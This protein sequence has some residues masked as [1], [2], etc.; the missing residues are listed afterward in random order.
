[1]SDD[2]RVEDGGVG[3][4][5]A[6]SVSAVSV[7]PRSAF[8]HFSAEHRA[9]IKA[10]FPDL[11]YGPTG[12]TSSSSAVAPLSSSTPALVSS[13]AF[14]FSESARL[15]GWQW[16]RMDEA[17]RRVYELRAAADKE[18]YRREVQL[19]N[20]NK[21]K[22]QT[23]ETPHAPH[24]PVTNT[25]HKRRAQQNIDGTTK[26]SKQQTNPSSRKKARPAPSASA[27]EYADGSVDLHLVGVDASVASASASVAVAP[28]VVDD[29][30]PLS[31]YLGPSST[32]S[33]E[34]HNAQTTT[35]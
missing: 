7:R 2:V 8:L 31:F 18:R 21:N 16:R 4:A 11:C 25:R 33:I 27:S 15:L 5:D 29:D 22:N 17:S 9:K 35:P 23:Q 19:A 26:T 6:N 10:A 30:L 34:A 12:E 3:T 13:G 1:M 24:A 20:S 14:G 32:P 28:P